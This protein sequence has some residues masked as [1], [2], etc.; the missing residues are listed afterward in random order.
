M[1]WNQTS[2]AMNKHREGQPLKSLFSRRSPLDFLSR[3]IILRG[4]FVILALALPISCSRLTHDMEDDDFAEVETV[5]S[6]DT[7]MRISQICRIN[8]IQ[9]AQVRTLDLFIFKD[10]PLRSLES[11]ERILDFET[12]DD[13]SMTFDRKLPEGPKLAVAVANSPWKFNTAALGSYD[14]IEQLEFE[15][16]DDDQDYPIM[17]G[18]G[19]FEAGRKTELSIS[20]LMCRVVLRKVTNNLSNYRRLEDPRVFLSNVN[21]KAEL[22]RTSGFRPSEIVDSV[23]LS[24]LPYDIGMFPQTV[25]KALYCYPND[26]PSETAGTP[27][28]ILVL[29]CEV[30]GS[31]CRYTAPLPPLA[32]NSTTFIDLTVDDI[33]NWSS[34]FF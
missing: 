19:T 2:K 9:L 25:N 32:R 11:H 3:F 10:N 24:P 13:G 34:E 7:R 22:L 16:G 1:Q 5:D 30:K 6:L 28:T 31:S 4:Y 21:P 12:D 17:S 27:R 23:G 29:D 14:S 20:P 15:L 8:D 26:S 18:E 33:A